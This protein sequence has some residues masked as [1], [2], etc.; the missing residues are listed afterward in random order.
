MSAN[1]K[2]AVPFFGVTNVESSLRFYVDGLGFTMKHQWVPV[3]DEHYPSDGKIRWC[4]LEL[5][6]AAI[7][8]QEFTLEG[9]PKESLGAGASVSPSNAKT[10]WPFIAISRLE[11]FKLVNVH[12]WETVYGLCRLRTLTAIEWI[13][14]VPRTHPKK[15]NWEKRNSPS[16]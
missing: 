16:G 5:G 3:G 4:W 12:L 6:G 9:R 14:R 2:Q 13:F 7:M 10:H 8:L 15:A 1:V 11:V